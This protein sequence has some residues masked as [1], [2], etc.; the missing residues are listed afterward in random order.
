MATASTILTAWSCQIGNDWYGIGGSAQT[1]GGETI[2]L[3]TAAPITGSSTGIYPQLVGGAQVAGYYQ[4]QYPYQ[5]A[6]VI[7]GVT[8]AHY[9]HEETAE[10]KVE[11][12]KQAAIRQQAIDRAEELLVSLLD[13]PQR[14]Q[15]AEHQHF[16]VQVAGKIYRLKPY[17]RVRLL[18]AAGK[19]KIAYCI[20]PDHIHGLP[21][22]DVMLAQKLL[23]ETNEAHFLKTANASVIN[24]D[25]DL[26]SPI[27]INIMNPMPLPEYPVD[28]LDEA[29]EVVLAA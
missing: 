10:E 29:I 5:D 9:A 26:G 19:A 12:E 3:Q 11:R 27:G 28:A 1:Y 20:H 24:A 16:D 22:A 14:Q 17:D 21:A 13:D 7:G 8:Y 6:N 25:G 2:W 4:Y 15:Y 23:L 18:D